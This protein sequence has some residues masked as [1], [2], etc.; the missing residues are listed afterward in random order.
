MK[1]R[2]YDAHMDLKTYTSER[3]RQTSLAN[4][5]GAQSQLVWQWSNGVRPVPDDRCA[6]IEKATEGQVTCEEMR[7]D[8]PWHRIADRSW[9]W[10]PKGRPALD[11]T[12]AAA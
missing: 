1:H 3:G 10:H 6:A 8:L 5:I 2:A 11:V 9:R 4:A 7:P 12:K